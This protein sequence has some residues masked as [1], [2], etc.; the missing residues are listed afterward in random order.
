ML[1]VDQYDFDPTYGYSLTA[2]LAL[3]APQ[4]PDGF[5]DFWRQTYAATLKIPSNVELR[6][7]TVS[8]PG[9]DVL[10]IEYDGLEGFRV[11][12][13]LTV[14]RGSIA[15][16]GVVFGHGYGGRIVPEVIAGRTAIGIFPCARGFDRSASRAFPG[17]APRHVISNIRDRDRYA[18]RY[19][20]ADLFAATTALLALHPELAGQ[21]DYC[22]QSFG[23]G[24]GA[25]ALPWETRWR[26]AFLDIPSFGNHPIR[27]HSRGV[28]S[29]ESVR[30]YVVNHPEVLN[31]LPYFDAATAATFA[32][33]PTL[34]AAALFDPAVAPPGQFS[35][36]N[37]LAGPKELFIRSAAHCEWPGEAEENARLFT[38]AARWFDC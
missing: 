4:A 5:A 14:P 9:A 27:L 3:D 16:R 18:H 33:T 26:R 29:G 23:G 28:G 36:Y 38:T 15:A 37:A 34:V 1:P 31:V 7:A 30:Q 25:L 24:I 8:L 2:L 17:D 21:V 10:E 19:C 35:I 12:G 11:G 20:T 13:W 22:G 32:T 6:K